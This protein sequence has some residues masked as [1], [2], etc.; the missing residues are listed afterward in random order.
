MARVAVAA[1]HD[2]PRRLDHVGGGEQV[3][4][5]HPRPLRRGLLARRH[6]GAAADV[7][8]QNVDRAPLLLD[9]VHQRLRGGRI[10]DVGCMERGAA[11]DLAGSRLRPSRPRAA[12]ATLAPSA[13]SASAMA[14]PMPRLA[15]TT[16]AT[17]PSRSSFIGLRPRSSARS[18]RDIAE[19]A[20]MVAVGGASGLKNILPAIAGLL[21]QPDGC[22]EIRSAR[23]ERH[24]GA[25]THPV[26]Y[27]HIANARRVSRNLLGRDRSR[28]RRCCRCRS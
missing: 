13:A 7:A 8:D 1:P 22:C 20:G 24:G 21:D 16:N 9:I 4:V 3:D 5:Q 12:S 27:V 15:P 17:R 19:R 10:G 25:A 28:A 26:L 18:C 6:R 14:K 11:A 2:R 23:P